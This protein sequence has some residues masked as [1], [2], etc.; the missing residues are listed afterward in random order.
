MHPLQAFFSYHCPQ[1]VLSR[2]AQTVIITVSERSS[3]GL[4]HGAVSYWAHSVNNIWDKKR[5]RTERESC[6]IKTKLYLTILPKFHFNPSSIHKPV[7]RV[8]LQTLSLS[9]NPSCAP[10]HKHHTALKYPL[11]F[12][13][14]SITTPLKE[15]DFSSNQ[16]LLMFLQQCW[17]KDTQGKG[18]K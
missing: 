1:L 3:L 5:R 8:W 6:I 14:L 17:N 11:H 18:E 12:S 4:S 13:F 10:S 9:L 15:Q 2:C 7:L 16:V